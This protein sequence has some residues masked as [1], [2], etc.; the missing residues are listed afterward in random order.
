[1]SG[2][3]GPKT[4]VNETTPY[5]TPEIRAD[6]AV[7]TLYK[8]TIE[9][10]T[11]TPDAARLYARFEVAQRTSGGI[12][13]GLAGV[14]PDPQTDNRP[15]WTQINANSHRGILPD[16]DIPTRLWRS[17]DGGPYTVT[18]RI[19]GGCSNRIWLNPQLVGGTNPGIIVTIEA[20][21][22]Y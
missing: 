6:A 20:E 13:P 2:Q 10:T 22:R 3:C 4:D 9:G 19:L 21:V 16:G 12:I 8:I 7:E 18:R 11:G 15:L 14:D 17:E 5:Y 1:M